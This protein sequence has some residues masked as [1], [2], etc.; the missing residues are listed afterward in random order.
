M[1]ALPAFGSGSGGAGSSGE[2]VVKAESPAVTAYNQGVDF[3]KAR[4]FAQAEGK[5]E[6]AVKLDPRFAE[7]YNNLA[8]T[9]RKQGSANFQAYADVINAKS[10]DVSIEGIIIVFWKVSHI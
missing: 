9:L 4:Q 8:F 6:Q 2:P 10:K 7:A 1:A 3:M 5:F